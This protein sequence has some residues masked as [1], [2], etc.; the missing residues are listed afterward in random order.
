MGAQAKDRVK[1]EYDECYGLVGFSIGESSDCIVA[2]AGS[3]SQH[4]QLHGNAEQDNEGG[5]ENKGLGSALS[6]AEKAK[7]LTGSSPLFPNNLDRYYRQKGPRIAKVVRRINC[8]VE[9]SEF[10]TV[11][12]GKSWSSS[13]AIFPKGFKSRISYLSV[14]DPTKKCFYVSR[15]VDAGLLGPLFMVLVEECPTKV[16]VHL[17]ASRYWDMVRDK[18]NKEIRKQ[19][20]LGRQHLPP[21]QPPGSLDGL[22]MFGFTSP[23]IMQAIEAIDMNRVCTDYWKSRPLVQRLHN[24]FAGDPTANLEADD[25][26]NPIKCL[27]KKANPEEFH[28]LY[29][30]LSDNKPAVD[31]GLVTQLSF[32]KRFRIVQNSFDASHDEF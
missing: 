29:S 1:L 24:S 5:N 13:Q 32:R 30:I 8:S 25:K 23:A 19:H 9:P 3:H 14:L 26:A 17:S 28:S 6:L 10:G 4:S 20:T 31:I 7:P 11:L 12:P 22:E 18:V 2:N 15:I 16:F 21:L 27:F